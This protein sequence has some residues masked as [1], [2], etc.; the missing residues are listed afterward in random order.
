MR[1]CVVSIEYYYLVAPPLGAEMNPE[2]T[3]F[4]YPQ[5]LVFCH[6]LP[7]GVNRVQAAMSKKPKGAEKA[8]V[9]L[10]LAY[11]RFMKAGNIVER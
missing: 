10:A 5:H 6:R 7:L 2:I 8:Y 1:F 11:D 3:S 4:T 9:K